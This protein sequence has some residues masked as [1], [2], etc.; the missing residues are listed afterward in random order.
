VGTGLDVLLFALTLF[1]IWKQRCNRALHGLAA[2]SLVRDVL[3]VVLIGA[4][5]AAFVQTLNSYDGIPAPVLLLLMLL[6]VF[7]YVTSQTVFGRR[8]YSVVSNMVATRLSGINVHAVKQWIFGIMGVMCALAG[9]VVL[10][11]VR[12]DET[13][14]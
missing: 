1:L 8:V 9:A 11:P 4:L 6:G 14:S 2:H 5:L 12:P 7:S 10:K 3:H 13:A